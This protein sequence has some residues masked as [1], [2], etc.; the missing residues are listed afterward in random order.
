MDIEKYFGN[1]KKGLT[2]YVRFVILCKLA[3]GKPRERAK[4]TLK[5]IQRKETRN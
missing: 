3:R 2:I 5:T 4:R 1:K